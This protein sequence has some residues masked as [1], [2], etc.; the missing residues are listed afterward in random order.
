MTDSKVGRRPGKRE[1]LAGAAA[2]VL[3][4]QGVERTTLADIA[5]AADVPVGNV[6]Y[7]FKTKDQLVEAAI[8][9]QADHLRETIAALDRLP[10]PR[11]RLKALVHGWVDG[12]DLAARFG[13]PTGTLAAELDKRADGL[14]RAVADVMRRLVDWIEGQFAAM[15]RDDARELAVALLAAYQGISLL[16]NTFRDPEL[17]ATEGRRLERWI[18]SLA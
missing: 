3:H 5:R 8:D 12:R 18:D 4:E 1:R 7:Y 2:R 11:E 9:T 10:T 15:G 6:Y 13:C 16:T 14:D 17:M